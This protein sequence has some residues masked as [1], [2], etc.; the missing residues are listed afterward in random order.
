M[1]PSFQHYGFRS[2]MGKLSIVVAVMGI[3]S[4][5]QSQHYSN[6]IHN[7]YSD[8]TQQHLQPS[9]QYKTFSSFI[10]IPNFYRR[11]GHRSIAQN[12]DLLT[13]CSICSLN[14]LPQS[15]ALATNYQSG[16]ISLA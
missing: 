16:P 8:T 3:I 14:T 2:Y 6:S 9:D 13:I 12:D 10:G 11:H 5:M 1:P 7:P 4:L 15:K